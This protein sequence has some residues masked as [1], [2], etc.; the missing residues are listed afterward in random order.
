MGVS[1]RIHMHST[2][3][4]VKTTPKMLWVPAHIGM[5][6]VHMVRVATAIVVFVAEWRSLIDWLGL[7]TGSWLDWAWDRTQ[8]TTS[9]SLHCWFIIIPH[10]NSLII[11]G[12]SLSMSPSPFWVLRGVSWQPTT[13]VRPWYPTPL[14]VPSFEHDQLYFIFTVKYSSKP[15]KVCYYSQN[16]TPVIWKPHAWYDI[17]A[18]VH[19]CP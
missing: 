8:R 15:L 12:R 13:K 2:L 11:S 9:D 14:C 17:V 7:S 1:D 5:H 4:N 3:W 18:N 19:V 16:H 10:C 6:A